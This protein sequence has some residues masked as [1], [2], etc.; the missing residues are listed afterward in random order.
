MMAKGVPLGI[1]LL[2][3][4]PT[5][6]LAADVHRGASIAERWCS[7]CHVVSARQKHGSTEAPPFS[8][9]AA[10]RDFDSAKI[11]FWLLA[12]HPPMQGLDLARSD[13]SD[14]AAYIATQG[15]AP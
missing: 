11:A 8:E 9:I 12:P 1:C 2:L 5:H 3:I 13:V 4:G 15:E 14:L 6:G 7:S 10:R